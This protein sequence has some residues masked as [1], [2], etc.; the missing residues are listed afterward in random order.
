MREKSTLGALD[1]PLVTHH[2]FR[3]SSL[4]SFPRYSSEPPFPPVVHFPIADPLILS[5]DGLIWLCPGSDKV[6]R[7]AAGCEAWMLSA[8][9]DEW[10]R[11]G[12]R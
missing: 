10:A 2:L 12:W 1:A 7:A 4:F 5:K 9:F 6:S 8:G 11:G 3:H